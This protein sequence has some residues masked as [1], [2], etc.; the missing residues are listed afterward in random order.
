MNTLCG[1][2]SLLS[3]VREGMSEERRQRASMPIGRHA[4]P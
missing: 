3:I 1:E 2:F 4:F